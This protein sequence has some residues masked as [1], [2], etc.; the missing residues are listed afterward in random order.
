MWPLY[1]VAYGTAIVSA[2][3]FLVATL[4][5]FERKRIK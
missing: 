1:L 5:G 3:V 2:L 4:H